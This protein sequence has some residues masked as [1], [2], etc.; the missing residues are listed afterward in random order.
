M[1]KKKTDDLVNAGSEYSFPASD[2]PSFMGGAAIAGAPPEDDKPAHGHVIRELSNPDEAK[3]G[4]DERIRTRAHAI[5]ERRPL[6]RR[7]G[8]LAAAERETR[9]GG[10][11]DRSQEAAEGG[12]PPPSQEAEKMA[13]QVKVAMDARNARSKPT[14]RAGPGGKKDA[15]ATTS[16]SSK[17]EPSRPK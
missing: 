10:S 1:A 17:G 13:E 9:G 7:S 16:G 3:P 14:K 4:A 5:W 15:T 6:R 12:S 8:P 2:P 11:D